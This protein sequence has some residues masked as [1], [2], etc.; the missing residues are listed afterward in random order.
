MRGDVLTAAG[1]W[2]TS[3]EWWREDFWQH[4]EWDL[5]LVFRAAKGP[6]EHRVYR[7][8]YDVKCSAWFVR[9]VFD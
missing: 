1:P 4:E 2:R 6:S 9:G 5:E 3:G 7:I 8:Y